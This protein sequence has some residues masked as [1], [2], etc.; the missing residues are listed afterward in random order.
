M[1]IDRIIGTGFRNLADFDL[2]LDPAFTVLH[3]ENAQGKTN[4]LEA[5]WYLCALKPLR[6]RR[7]SDLIGWEGEAAALSAVST[8][9]TIQSRRKLKLESGGRTLELDGKRP[10]LESWFDGLRA[11]VF[12]PADT[13]IVRG[14]PEH[15]RRWVDRAAFTARPA[16]LEL[17]RA[18]QRVLANKGAT[19]RSDRPDTVLLDT[20]DEQLAH[21][22]AQLADRRAALL[23]ELGRWV[24]G[25]VDALAGGRVNVD[26][27]LR[28]VA[29]G[30]TPGERH[31]S[32][33]AALKRHRRDE[34]RR[35]RSLTGVQMDDVVVELQG[36]AARTFASQGQVRTLVL[37]LKLAELMAARERGRVPL[38]LL[39]DLSS[40]L[41]QGRTGRLI[42]LLADL[43]AQVVATTTDP[44]SLVEASGTEPLQLRVEN[45]RITPQ[46]GGG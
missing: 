23:V 7:A 37:A 26:V 30:Q 10:D 15:R 2:A 18:H 13:D 4:T 25:L 27:R 34:L 8:S 29:R 24:P 22:G 35:R 40:E 43:G 33:Q 45:G 28:T 36:H 38:F 16:H 1:R 17:V 14:S 19:L 46:K 39:D 9:D 21:L 3:G 11:I 44:R 41:D 6:T 42:R 32:L 31:A 12:Q 20:L 5:I